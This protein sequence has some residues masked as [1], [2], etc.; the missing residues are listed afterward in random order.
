MKTIARVGDGKV[1]VS[2]VQR[3]TGK[4]RAIAKIL[5]LASAVDTLAVG[6]AKPRHADAVSEHK[7]LTKVR[8]QS[9]SDLL[10]APHNLVT[11]NQRQLRIWQLA[12]DNVKIGPTNAARCH[13]N[14]QFSPARLRIGNVAQSEGCAR[15]LEDHRPHS[16]VST[17]SRPA[18]S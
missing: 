11:E 12:I 7:R 13:A 16:D 15:S 18:A 10:D 8:R 5:A 4:L 2:S 6:P 14:E 1:R 17:G 9:L 3:V